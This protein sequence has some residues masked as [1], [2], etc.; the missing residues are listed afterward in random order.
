M[1]FTKENINKN[2]H[3]IRDIDLFNIEYM[4]SSNNE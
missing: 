4:E 3:A 1:D 2:Y